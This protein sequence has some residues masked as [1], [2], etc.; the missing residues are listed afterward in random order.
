MQIAIYRSV[1]MSEHR[2]KCE[3]EKLAFRTGTIIKIKV[4]HKFHI[5]KYTNLWNIC[6]PNK[7][8]YYEN[9]FVNI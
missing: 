8:Y 2:I 1:F 5:K 7:M 9:R 6:Q 4:I 3:L